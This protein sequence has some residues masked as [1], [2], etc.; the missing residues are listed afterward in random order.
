MLPL[1]RDF[2]YQVGAPSRPEVGR[3][4]RSPYPGLLRHLCVTD[5]LI[6]SNRE[7]KGVIFVMILK[8]DI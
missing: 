3:W 5:Y 8:L 4:G 6:N 1:S 7:A 2:T